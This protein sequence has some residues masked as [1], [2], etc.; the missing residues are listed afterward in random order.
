MTVF[1]IEYNLIKV[2]L[3]NKQTIRR[4]QLILNRYRKIVIIL[5]EKRYAKC[6]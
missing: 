4:D 2:D 1:Q 6:S 5:G 3:K